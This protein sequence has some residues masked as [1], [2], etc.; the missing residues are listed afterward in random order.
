M[1]RL[2]LVFLGLLLCFS[3]CA[4]ES[5]RLG[6]LQEFLNVETRFVFNK[7]SKTGKSISKIYGATGFYIGDALPISCVKDEK[8]L[9]RIEFIPSFLEEEQTKSKIFK[10]RRSKEK[11][12]DIPVRI[13][14]TSKKSHVEMT[15]M[16]SIENIEKEKSDQAQ[17]FTFTI[18]NKADSKRYIEFEITGREAG[19]E[20]IFVSYG[21]PEYKIVDSTCDVFETIHFTNE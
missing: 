13:E 9:F 5:R 15:A 21:S 10:M 17:I 4:E 1:K 19:D 11:D 7:T 18:K 20:Q 16:K 6:N 12:I 3:L 14:I 8:M 2:W